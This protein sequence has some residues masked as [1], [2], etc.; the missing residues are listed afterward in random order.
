MNK[1][2]FSSNREDVT[3]VYFVYNN[4]RRWVLGLGIYTQPK[5]K[6]GVNV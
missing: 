5:P 6:T 4:N 1:P 3:H 2:I